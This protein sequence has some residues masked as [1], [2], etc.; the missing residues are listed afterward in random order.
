MQSNSTFSIRVYCDLSGD[1]T[2]QRSAVS[3]KCYQ[4]WVQE[5]EA[6]FIFDDFDKYEIRV[7]L[8]LKPSDWP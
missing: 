3:D 8:P 6:I 4:K 5:N 2:E 7:A 1:T